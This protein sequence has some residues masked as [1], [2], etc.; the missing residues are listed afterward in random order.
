MTKVVVYSTSWCNICHSVMDWLDKQGVEYE[1]RDLE[2]DKLAIK[3]L[4]KAL[5]KEWQTVPVTVIGD[6]AIDG[7]NRPMIKKAL[8]KHGLI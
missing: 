2:A 6:E 7:F 3:E 4:E 5:G 8:E 1:K